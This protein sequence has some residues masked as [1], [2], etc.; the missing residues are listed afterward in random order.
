VLIRRVGLIMIG[1][2]AQSSAGV[3]TGFQVSRYLEIDVCVQIQWKARERMESEEDAH[4]SL[5]WPSPTR[6][7]IGVAAYAVFHLS[8]SSP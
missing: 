7:T 1:E 8:A 2:Q 4:L 6:I 5:F 3:Q